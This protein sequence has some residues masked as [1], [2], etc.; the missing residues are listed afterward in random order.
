MQ[1]MP[2]EKR[3]ARTAGA[4]YLLVVVTGMFG[5]A[6]VPGQLIVWDDP[7]ATYANITHHETE[8]RAGIAVSAVCYIAFTFLPLALYRL[9]HAVDRTQAHIMVITALLSVP[10]SLL[11]L[12]NKLKI[13]DVLDDAYGGALTLQEATGKTM[14]YLHQYNNG[15]LI[16]ML[17]WGIWL[18]PLGYLIIRSAFLPKAIGILVMAGGVGYLIMCFGQIMIPDYISIPFFNYISLMPTIGELSICFWLLIIG[19]KAHPTQ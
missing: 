7:A 10:I 9:L 19:V 13:L 17:F 14:E 4:I 3:T 11:N 6:Y 16:A 18:L 1:G 8:F 5:L 12:I 2:N 15:I